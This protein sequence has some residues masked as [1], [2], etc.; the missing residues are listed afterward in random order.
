MGGF[1]AETIGWRYIFILVS[2][3]SALVSVAGILLF[4]ETYAPVILLRIAEKE[5]TTKEVLNNN[6][7]FAQAH[8]NR[9]DYLLTNLRRPFMLL[10]RSIV[11]FMLSAYM[12]LY[13]PF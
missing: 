5:N 2:G 6:P 8:G 3:L 9:L 13:V 1:M 10:T 12:A 7:R 4:R 11:C